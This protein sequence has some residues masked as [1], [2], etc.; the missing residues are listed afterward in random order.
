ME[1]TDSEKY[2]LL[3][4][5][6]VLTL[7][8]YTCLVTRLLLDYSCYLITHLEAHQACYGISS[9]SKIPMYVIIIVRRHITRKFS[10]ILLTS[11]F[12]LL[13]HIAN[14]LYHVHVH[15]VTSI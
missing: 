6:F 4:F 10:Y 5:F 14:T 11:Y 3:F 7:L 13:I 8:I 12:L 9:N 1:Q 15:V 2:L